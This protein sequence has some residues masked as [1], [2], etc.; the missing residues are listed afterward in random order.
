MMIPSH[1]LMSCDSVNDS[2][3][4]N[5]KKNPNFQLLHQTLEDSISNASPSPS[6]RFKIPESSPSKTAHW[7]HGG[8]RG[9]GF[10]SWTNGHVN[11]LFL[12]SWKT[13]LRPLESRTLEDRSR[14]SICMNAVIWKLSY[15]LAAHDTLC[16]MCKP[17]TRL[18]HDLVFF[19]YDPLGAS[20]LRG[21]CW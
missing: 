4:A 1:V 6:E 5:K 9:R 14:M 19:E 12:E 17:N 10:I 3:E 21:P 13:L 20:D 2:I 7:Q 8:Q 16:Y 15:L 18:Y 11:A